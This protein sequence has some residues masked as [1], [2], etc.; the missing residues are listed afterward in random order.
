[1]SLMEVETGPVDL[2]GLASS[3]FHHPIRVPPPVRVA[4]RELFP[5]E[6]FDT[7]WKFAA[8]R[9][10]VYERRIAGL[11][12]PWTD[13]S[14][15]SE[16]RFTNCFR[17]SDRV[18]QF[19]INNVIYEGTQ[20]P[21]EVVFRILLFK[22]FNKISTWELLQSELGALTRENFSIVEYDKVL[23][24]AMSAG[25]K[26]YSAAYVVPP[27]KMGEVRKHK[28]HLRL[29]ERM[30]DE[31]ISDRLQD[32]AEMQD[33]FNVLRSYPAMGN[34]LA[35]QFLIDIN[36]SEVLYFDEMD[37]VVPGPGAR[38]GLRKCFG[39]R[40][41]GIEAEIIRYMCDSQDEHFARLGL[42][43]RGLQGARPLQ[44]VDCQ[45]LFCEVDKYA[46]VA[47]PEIE[48]YSGRSR[49]K[50]KFVAAR[51]PL[52]PVFPRKWLLDERT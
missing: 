17:A 8:T 33:A 12:G 24:A 42:E 18:S 43:F 27:P 50:Q 10:K 11:P 2:V 39:D 30:L 14:I 3:A 5:T 47:H 34:F 7:Y 22:F 29:L 1:M 25:K 49:I 28:N 37:F 36:Y 40:S 19:L 35:Y 41:R 38:D 15:I 46:R 6:V 32:C 21:D 26:I 44:L 51:A 4:G 48:G 16:H 31:S 13:D 23:S 9:Q 20:D 52:N 45:N